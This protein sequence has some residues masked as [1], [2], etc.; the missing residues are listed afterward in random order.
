MG[1]SLPSL[2]SFST[3]KGMVSCSRCQN[4]KP[5]KPWNIPSL[6]ASW[7]KSAT[8]FIFASYAYWAMICTN[9]AMMM[10]AIIPGSGSEDN[11]KPILYLSNIPS[12]ERVPPSEKSPLKETYRQHLFNCPLT[13]FFS[14]DMVGSYIFFFPFSQMGPVWQKRG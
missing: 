14:E 6:Y 11:S 3:L 5:N 10:G 7:Q 13:F 8:D 1:G 2:Y 12:Q 4:I 9:K